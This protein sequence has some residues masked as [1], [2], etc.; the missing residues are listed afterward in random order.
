MLTSMEWFYR[1]VVAKM[2]DR[3][4]FAVFGFIVAALIATVFLVWIP[5]TSR[6]RAVTDAILV[7]TLLSALILLWPRAAKAGIAWWDSYITELW[8][9]RRRLV[10]SYDVIV[11]VVLFVIGAV[12]LK[13]E[14]I[15]DNLV[16]ETYR[17][18]ANAMWLGAF[19]GVIISL[20]GVYEHGGTWSHNFNLWHL[21]RAF[22][23]AA[24]GLITALIFIA[25]NPSA[26]PNRPVI[27]IA[28]LVLGTQEARFFTFLAEIGRIFVQV[29][30]TL[31]PTGVQLTKVNPK[32]G[33]EGTPVV[34]TG[35]GFEPNVVVKL[36]GVKLN[37]IAAAADGNSVAGTVPKL[38]KGFFDVTAFN[39]SAQTSA[40]LPD[41]FE[42][43]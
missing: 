25:L 43:L 28:A 14:Y 23:G 4:W 26:A 31:K 7:V 42:Y 1:R 38:S 6:Q 11:L 2:N 27:Y 13:N 18:F 24:T 29:P 17:I 19:G 21:G 22:S 10:F 33:T 30:D 41:C 12:Y 40:I 36:G 3:L 16:G 32:E 15:H 37:G 34:V 9:T 20:K 35:Q 5:L 8:S 39:P